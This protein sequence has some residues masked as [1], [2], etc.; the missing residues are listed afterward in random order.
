MHAGDAPY[1]LLESILRFNF[2][3]INAESGNSGIT[4]RGVD[5]L[6]CRPGTLSSGFRGYPSF[7]LSIFKIH[8]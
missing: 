8:L 6:L 1:Y 5:N 7:Y 4:G 3:S 2:I